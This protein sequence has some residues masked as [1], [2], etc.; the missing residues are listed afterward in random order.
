MKSSG[1][2]TTACV[3]SRQALVK[4]Y[5]CL[6]VVTKREPIERERP[7]RHGAKDML[8]ALSTPALDGDLGVDTDAAVLGERACLGTNGAHGLHELERALTGRVA[9]KWRPPFSPSCRAC[10]AARPEPR[11]CPGTDEI[12]AALLPI[13]RAPARAHTFSNGLGPGWYARAS[14]ECRGPGPR[15]RCA[16]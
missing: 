3:P 1:E 7:L 12:K 10:D 4:R 14:P 11:A 16:A 6:P 8:E 13:W 15:A 2:S 5:T 9:E